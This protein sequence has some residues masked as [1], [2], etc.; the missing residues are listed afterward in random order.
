ME[1]VKTEQDST[2]M[3][4]PKA[5]RKISVSELYEGFGR[6]VSLE[7]E[8]ELNEI[9]GS[10]KNE[11]QSLL[12]PECYEPNSCKST[13]QCSKVSKEHDDSL[14]ATHSNENVSFDLKKSFTCKECKRIFRK[15]SDLAKHVLIHTG[16]KPF[17]CNICS[18]EFRQKGDMRTHIKRH[19]GE[20]R[21]LCPMCGKVFVDGL[22]LKSHDNSYW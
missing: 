17:V 18:K 5:E 22:G 1:T 2:A 9:T 21:H 4:A 6:D 13:R 3:I 8:D 19:T 10:F 11:M 15:R 16:E 14:Q 7:A 12:N 20:K